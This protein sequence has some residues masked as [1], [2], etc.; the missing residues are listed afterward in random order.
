ML[1]LEDTPQVEVAM[2][3]ALSH[4]AMHSRQGAKLPVATAAPEPNKQ[5][6]KKAKGAIL[7]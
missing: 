3:D 5:P 2:L 7:V 4:L 6:S 1:L